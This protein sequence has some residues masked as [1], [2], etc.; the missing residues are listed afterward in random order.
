MRGHYSPI[1]HGLSL[2]KIPH[3]KGPP[4]NQPAVSTIHL[5]SVGP[6][7][8]LL[9]GVQATFVKT[10]SVNIQV[11]KQIS[12]SRKSLTP[13]MCSALIRIILF[14]TIFPLVN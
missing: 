3:G 4:I 12:I 8:T 9:W 10:H 14:L 5:T 6:W 7:P 11:F 13:S 1:E 2:R